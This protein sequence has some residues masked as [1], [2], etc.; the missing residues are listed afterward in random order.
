MAIA[1]LH[2]ELSREGRAANDTAVARIGP[3]NFLPLLQMDATGTSIA[4]K[5][6]AGAPMAAFSGTTRNSG[7]VQDPFF[8]LGRG[9]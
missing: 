9:A 4:D 6:V 3:M 1:C 8:Q 5:I 7:N 2:A